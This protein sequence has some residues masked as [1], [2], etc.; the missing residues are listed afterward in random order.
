MTAAATGTPRGTELRKHFPVG[1]E[2]EGKVIEL[3]LKRGEIKLSIKAVEQDTERS[4]YQQYRQQVTREAKFGTLA[5]LLS[6]K[7]GAPKA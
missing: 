3:D 2:L 6:K 4:A 7:S 1:S 5:D